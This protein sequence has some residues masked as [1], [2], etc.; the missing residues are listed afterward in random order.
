MNIILLSLIAYIIAHIL[1]TL[2][3]MLHTVFNIYV[4][5]M[6]AMDENSL[7]EGYEKTKPWHPIY[8]IIIFSAAAYIFFL[9]IGSTPELS[10]LLIMCTTWLITT[11]VIDFT[12]RVLIKHPW[13]MSAKD[14]YVHYQP[15]ITFIYVAI[16]ISPLIG[17]WFIKA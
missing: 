7:G 3:G 1:V 4:R 6:Q 13:G 8:N 9:I 17:A 15:W 5:K 2:V 10:S 16:F 12:G 14:F 11:L